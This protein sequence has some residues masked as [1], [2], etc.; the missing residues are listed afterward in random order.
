MYGYQPQDHP[1]QEWRTGVRTRMLVS[2][3]T[4]SQQLCI[5]EQWCAPR[6]GEAEFWVE[7]A[8]IVTSKGQSVLV[9]AGHQH[10]FRN[11]DTQLHVLAVLA[12]PAFEAWSGSD[13]TPT[14]HWSRQP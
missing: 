10:G 5:F 2:A 4:G 1:I 3:L 8:H 13:M 6:T 9:P 7:G 14:R 12:A 11:T